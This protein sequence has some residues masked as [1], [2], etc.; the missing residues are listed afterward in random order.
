MKVHRDGV[1]LAFEEAGRGDPPILLVHGWGTDRSIWRPLSG[2]LHRGHRTIAIDLRGFGE[3]DAP[4]ESYT[5]E[6]YSS[7]LAWIVETLALEKPIV[8]G[9]SMGAMIALD[10]AG[11]YPQRL[12]AAVL[13]EGMIAAP[14]LVAGLTPILEEVR[15]EEHRAFIA[16]LMARLA[17]AYLEPSHLA[18]LSAIA[19]SSPK[20]VLVSAMEGIIAFDS[21]AAAARV[22]SPLLFLGT[23]AKYAD[24]VHLGR[25]CPQLVTGQLVGCHHYF[26]LEVPDQI[27]AMVAR[28]LATSLRP[29]S[30]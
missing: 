14:D 16:K 11:R 28:F 25:L 12:G 6:R 19:A 2:H 3:S 10:F 22:A 4:R 24:L 15:G 1:A 7:D 13:L 8:V 17:G 21:I 20:H 9:H 30:D 29:L 26:P 27:D 23:A 5:I 18:R